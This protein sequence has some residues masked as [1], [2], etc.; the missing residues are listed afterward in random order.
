MNSSI[1][2]AAR[3]LPTSFPRAV[4]CLLVGVALIQASWILVVPPF[5]GIDEWDHAYRATAVA[6]GEWHA[7]PTKATRDTG[8]FVRVPDDI[9]AASRPECERLP[10]TDAK[11]CV[12]TSNG[13]GTTSVASGAGR[14][15]PVFYAIIGYASLPFEGGSA[16]YAMRAAA[17]LLCLVSS[18][19]P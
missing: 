13:D 4:A 1:V 12:G 17:A 18:R 10:Y 14:Y 3:L 8:A 5:R 11:D 16:L 7:D 2:R 9:V 19:W 15:N 6:H